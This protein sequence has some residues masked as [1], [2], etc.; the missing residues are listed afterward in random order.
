[1]LL[2]RWE[3]STRGAKPLSS[4]ARLRLVSHKVSVRESIR[5]LEFVKF[6]ESAKET[7]YYCTSVMIQEPFSLASWKMLRP[8][9]FLGFSFEPWGVYSSVN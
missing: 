3:F 6:F 1:M 8:L 2:V 5:A 7:K 4:E 9:T